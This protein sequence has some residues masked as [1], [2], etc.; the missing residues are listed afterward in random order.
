MVA[1]FTEFEQDLIYLFTKVSIEIRKQNAK[2]LVA[3]VDVFQETPEEDYTISNCSEGGLS[4]VSLLPEA[5]QQTSKYLLAVFI[6]HI[7]AHR[8][9][10]FADVP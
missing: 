6:G 3:A 10:L 5:H 4:N 9:D 7:A 8:L 2:G 1:C